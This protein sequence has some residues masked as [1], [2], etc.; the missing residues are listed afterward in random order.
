MAILSLSLSTSCNT[1]PEPAPEVTPD[2]N[3]V[4]ETLKAV[5][6]AQQDFIRRT[7]RY[8]LTYDELVEAYLLKERPSGE[9]T[10]YDVTLKPSPDAVSYTVI[11]TP[12]SERER[13]RH[14][15][16]DK[17]GVIRS[18]IGRAATAESPEV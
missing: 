17:T 3:A 4:I 10:G 13:Y 11:A 1:S 18:E 15:F 6:R 2:E 8:A 12:R 14:F 5:N 16:T 7:R 9:N